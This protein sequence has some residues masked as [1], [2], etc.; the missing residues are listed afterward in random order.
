MKKLL[1]LLKYN[2]TAD[3]AVIAV[4]VFVFILAVGSFFLS[5]KRHVRFYISG[6]AQM[7][8]EYGE[9]FKDPGVKAVAIGSFTFPRPLKVSCD[10]QVDT[11]N[12][13]SYTLVY[14]VQYNSQ[15]Y[16]TKRIVDVVDTTPP[17]ITL[18]SNPDYKPSWLTGYID[19][20]YRAEDAHDGDL[21]A[22]V[23][24][25][26]SGDSIIYSV[27]DSSGN[28]AEVTRQIS[29]T[30]GRPEIKLFGE[31]SVTISARPHYADPGCAAYDEYGNDYGAYVK[32]SDTFRS[33]TPGSYVITYSITNSLGDT[34][35]AERNVTVFGST[36]VETVT[37]D[38]KVIY[39][40]FDDGPGPYTDALLDVLAKYG[41]KA[42]F[43]VT[44]NREQYRS[45]ITR[46]YNE[47]HAIGV[48][49][50]SHNYSSIYSSED[51]F[52]DDFT[53]TEDM[54]YS[55]TGSYTQLCRFPGGSSNTVSSFNSGIMSRLVSRINSMGYHYFDWNVDSNDA[56]GASSS[57]KVASNIISGCSGKRCAV[58]LQHDIK[59]FS[60]AAVESVLKWGTENGYSFRALDITSPGM[61]HNVAN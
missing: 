42:T 60:V 32:V 44:G 22:E 52:F 1:N 28:R 23:Q 4:A 19:E 50:Y 27:S 16:T 8:T 48:H 46:A 34:V 24:T 29:Y 54:I 30:S 55:L 41:A 40:T 9:E 33:D 18:S 7:Q 21:T 13:G 5:D 17:V 10:G 57:D 20:G 35:S 12:L 3:A 59:E 51:S 61:H 47:G 11:G 49:T 38:E 53:A 6:D 26:T 31:S 2:R 15:E 14:S 58:V 39:L 56:G 36:G 37:P 45:S 43:F 25:E